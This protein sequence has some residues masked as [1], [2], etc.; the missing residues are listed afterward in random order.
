VHSVD[1]GGA[2]NLP[3]QITLYTH[4]ATV[5]GRFVSYPD[6][7]MPALI[8]AIERGL[9]GGGVLSSLYQLLK[10]VPKGGLEPPCG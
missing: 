6:G 3:Y 2:L 7:R 8:E 10:L 1:I 9:F 5:P 4:A